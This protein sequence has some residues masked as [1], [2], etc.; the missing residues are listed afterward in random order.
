MTGLTEIAFEPPARASH[1]E[2][3]AVGI[4]GPTETDLMLR[5]QFD[6]GAGDFRVEEDGAGDADAALVVLVGHFDAA[7]R[8]LPVHRAVVRVDVDEGDAA[9]LLGDEFGDAD[10]DAVFADAEAVVVVDGER[11]AF[12]ADDVEE[13]VFVDGALGWAVVGAAEGD[14]DVGASA[15]ELGGCRFEHAHWDATW[16]G[17]W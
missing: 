17:S 3:I 8:V 16:G 6:V 10:V 14:A 4:S 12:D 5:R 13:G 15:G 7:G 9:E 2:Q 11:G 1:L